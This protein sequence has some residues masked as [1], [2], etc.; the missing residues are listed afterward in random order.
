MAGGRLEAS[1][2]LGPA[3]AHIVFGADGIV[4]F[5]PFRFKVEVYASISAGITID[6]WIGEITISIHI[7]ARIEL[8]GPN[9]HGKATFEIG[10]VS[11]TVPFGDTEQSGPNYIS[12]DAFVPK[13]L[14]E[15]APG[16]A[17]VL[18]AI[19]GK[20]ALP[21]GT[22]PGGAT[23]T[24]VADGS[25]E[26]PFEVLSEFELTVTSTVPTELIRADVTHDREPSRVL[27][28]APLGKSNLVSELDLALF[29]QLGQD[30]I[31]KLESVLL[32]DG[33]FPVGAW[34]APQDSDDKKVPKGDVI[35]AM[36]SLRL[37]AEANP[38]GT[39]PAEIAYYQV[40]APGPRKPLPFLPARVHR[41][42]LREEAARV[43]ALLPAAETSALV[44]AYG[45][46]WLAASGVGATTLAS[47]ERERSAPPRLGSLSEGLA[48]E[49]SQVLASAKEDQPSGE[50]DTRVHAPFAVAVLTAPAARERA[51]PFTS[52]KNVLGVVVT[53]APTLESVEAELSAGTSAKLL[54]FAPR[55][56]DRRETL[57]PTGSV[58]FTRSPRGAT[59]A[60]RARGSH[61][62][63]D[64]RLQAL[65]ASLGGVTRAGSPALRAARGPEKDPKPPQ[66]LLHAGEIAVLRLPN[67]SRDVSR[68]APRPRLF[69]EGG[70]ARVVALAVGGDVLVDRARRA[71]ELELEV[72]PTTERLVVTALAESKAENAAELPVS[73]WHSGQELAYVGASTALASGAVVRAEGGSVKKT[74]QRFGAG[75]VQA[76]ELIANAALVTTRFAA[77]A[78]SV[79]LVVE[80]SGSDLDDIAFELEGA[81]RS[82]G[83]DG[84]PLAPALLVMGNRSVLVYA[85]KPDKGPISV[86]VAASGDW[87]LAGVLASPELPAALVERLD[88]T[89]LD[90]AL[91]AH[92]AGKK[93]RVRL[94]F[95]PPPSEPPPRPEEPKKPH[96][97]G[98]AGRPLQKK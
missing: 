77:Q 98:R 60:V 15:A 83:S 64:L 54:R 74:R 94:G 35:N 24:A 96:Y 20:G 53:A 81:R 23:D 59:A 90:R 91:A 46:P 67:A 51:L 13:Y 1:A 68:K 17:R 28:L 45:K 37:V 3:W 82:L 66:P 7:G 49:E 76:A 32:D 70:S 40:E 63:G 73:G 39:L 6:V 56:A 52:V 58:P 22:G 78:N 61:A 55:A 31:G 47:L 8:E 10:P 79:A 14:E 36:Q 19:A 95:R 29:D 30:H 25:A 11:L 62:S 48:G 84:R 44:Y 72:P 86:A 18:A 34:G 5:D 42:V 75:W 43:S 88:G 21:P 50:I 2:T 87:T 80:A 33:S 85:V 92:G 9:F 65:S 38:F 27:G 97:P 12:W 71:R 93:G 57:A 41:V 16:V 89:G 26:R 4:F 69:V